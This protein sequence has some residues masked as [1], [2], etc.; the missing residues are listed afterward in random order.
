V[1]SS[2]DRSYGVERLEGLGTL[3]PA[4]IQP[5]RGKDSAHGANTLLCRMFLSLPGQAIG[6]SLGS[7]RP[8]MLASE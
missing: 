7:V 2:S 3:F 1:R 5:S 6:Q 4:S 8:V